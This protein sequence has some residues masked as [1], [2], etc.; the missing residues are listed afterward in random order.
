MLELLPKVHSV[1]E[2]DGPK[3]GTLD[4][5]RLSD[6]GSRDDTDNPRRLV[7]FEFYSGHPSR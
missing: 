5:R 6:I 3:K 2:R 7:I 1:E 4:S